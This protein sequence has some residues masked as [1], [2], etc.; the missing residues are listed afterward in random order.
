MAT[1]IDSRPRCIGSVRTGSVPHSSWRWGHLA[2]HAPAQV[3]PKV[4]P[5]PS[6]PMPSMPDSQ[7][8]D[9]RDQPQNELY[10]VT[11]N[12]WNWQ[13][14]DSSRTAHVHSRVSRPRRM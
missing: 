6:R 9:Y 10:R 4:G 7:F 5:Q 2:K 8:V 1:V 3:A 12:L 13:A 14:Y 11:R